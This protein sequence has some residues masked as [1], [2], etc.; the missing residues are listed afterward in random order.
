MAQKLTKEQLQ[1]LVGA[2]LGL[3][4]FSYCYVQFFWLPVFLPAVRR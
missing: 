1:Q 2:V 3:A 4:A